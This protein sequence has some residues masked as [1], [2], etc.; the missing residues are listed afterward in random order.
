MSNSQKEQQ[1]EERGPSPAKCW[2][3]GKREPEVDLVA[4]QNLYC[5]RHVCCNCATEIEFGLEA[6]AEHAPGL[7]TD[8]IEMYRSSLRRANERMAA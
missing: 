8:L 1:L 5:E 6:C 3:C 7:F 4:C 2:K